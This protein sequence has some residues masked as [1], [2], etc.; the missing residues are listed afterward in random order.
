MSEA[1]PNED[2]IGFAPDIHSSTDTYAKRFSGAAGLWLLH[3]QEDV[4]RQYLDSLKAVR[5]LDVGG[6]HGQNIPVCESLQLD[7]TITGST[8]ACDARVRKLS[9]S[10]RT[11]F[12]VGELN[13]LPVDD[14]NY[15]V[16]ISY[17][18][19]SHMQNWQKFIAELCRVS[20]DS[21][22]IDFASKRSINWFS[23]LAY[24]FKRGKEGDTRRYNVLSESEVNKIFQ[25]N[26]FKLVR[27]TPQFFF[28]MVIHRT[29]NNPKIS[30]LLEFF[31]RVLG[32]NYLF[33]SPV[34]SL[35]RRQLGV[36]LT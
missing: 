34:I 24:L 6:G 20:S 17:R 10:N 9:E 30:D 14:Q 31:P 29:L 25:Q 5:V 18:I 12:V 22:I 7:L 28:P 11:Q 36:E 35:Y 1:N 19:I 16:V 26:D 23:E 21:V 8:T 15:P 13:A 27:R 4:T 2:D 33:G 3:R 32:L